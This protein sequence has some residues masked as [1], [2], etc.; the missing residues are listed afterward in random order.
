MSRAEAQALWRDY[1][2]P[3]RDDMDEA[4]DVRY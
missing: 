2:S 4:F 3:G 1:V